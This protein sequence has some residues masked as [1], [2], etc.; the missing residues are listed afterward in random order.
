MVA[1]GLGAAGLLVAGALAARRLKPPI[2]GVTWASKRRGTLDIAWYDE[3]ENKLYRIF[4]SNRKGI[5][6]N[7]PKTYLGSI[8]VM[9]VSHMTDTNHHLA[10][11]NVHEEWVYFVVS[12]EGYFTKE[13]EAHV[14]QTKDFKVENLGW[15]V[16]ASGSGERDMTISARVLAGVETYRISQFLQDGSCESYDFETEGLGMVD[17][18]FPLRPESLIFVSAKIDGNW[19]PPE[20]LFYHEN[21]SSGSN[22]WETVTRL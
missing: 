1:A 16:L 3:E 19:V 20:F 10:S 11:I 2:T 5:N 21:F 13:Y 18:K 15:E 4:W 17:M 14:D 22:K 9:T 7:D 6:V 8:Q 12:K